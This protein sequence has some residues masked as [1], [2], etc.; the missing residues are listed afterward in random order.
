MDEEDQ[1]LRRINWLECC[2]FAHLF[3]TFR[4]SRQPTKLALAFCG[5]LSIYLAGRIL[6]GL[7]ITSQQ[8]WADTR[9]SVVVTELDAFIDSAAMSPEAREAYRQREGESAKDHVGVFSLLLGKARVVANEL[10]GGLLSFDCERVFGAVQTSVQTKLW[11]IQK[12]PVYGLVFGLIWLV[13]WAIFGGAI[14][15]A[16]AM[17][18][19]R[20]EQIGIRESIAFARS[21]FR[22]FVFAPLLPILII[23][24]GGLAPLIGGLV[25]LIPVVGEVLVGILFFLV[26][27]VGAGLALILIGAV[28][29][30]WLMYPTIAVEGSDAGDALARSISYVYSRPWRTGFYCLVSL[31]Y[32]AI[33]FVFVKLFVRIAL[34][35]AH[36]FLGWTMNLGGS[37]KLDAMWQSP[38]LG[39][40]LPFWGGFGGPELTG[41][42]WLGQFLLKGWIYALWGAVA[43]FV[44][45]FAY[46]ACTVI[47]FLLRREV[48]A[49]DLEDVYLDNQ[50]G[51]GGPPATAESDSGASE[52]GDTSLPVVEF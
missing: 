18:V 32:G 28:G 11:L 34:Y 52:S 24:I 23:L 39:M 16:A 50:D 43:A 25:G 30:S 13:V 36:L 19:A 4:I 9:G 51:E 15:R 6:D 46:S 31:C 48:D 14:C 42:A 20:D 26:L 41:A 27:A 8:P 7:W 37:N 29:G 12:H 33:C 22:S 38:D 35:L 10:S 49:T 1:T 5:I 45:S 40:G 2:G 47:Y 21:R 3:R 17:Q 44:V